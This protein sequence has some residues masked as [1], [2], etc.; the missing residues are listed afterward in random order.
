MKKLITLL[1]IVS[2]LL[3]MFSCS[4]PDVDD[5][6]NNTEPEDVSLSYLNGV[7]LKEYTI[8]YSANDLDYSKRAAE[9]IK[10]EIFARTGLT[11]PIITDDSEKRAHEIVIGN[12]S[13]DISHELSAEYDGLEFSI[14]ADE[15]SVALEGDYFIIA[16][17]AYYFIATYVPKDDYSATV[18]AEIQVLEPIVEEANNY[19]LLIGD[20]MGEYH[21][22]MFDYYENTYDYSDGEDFFYGYLLPYF[23]YSKTNSLSGV[24]DSAAGGTALSTGY[25]TYNAYVGIDKDGN[26]LQSLT[27]LFGSLGKKTGVMSTETETGATPASFS[28]HEDDRASSSDIRADQTE[29]KAQ[30]GTVIDCG[31]YNSYNKNQL[32]SLDNHIND[33]LS[34]L[35]SG[36]GFFLMYE[37]AYIDKYSHNND[38]E[39]TYKTVIRFNQAIARFMEFA[40]YNPDTMVI[41]TADHETGAL[42]PDDD[43]A[44][45]FNHDDHTGADVFVFSYG[46]GAEELD[47]VTMENIEIPMFIANCIGVEDFGDRSIYIPA[48]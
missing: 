40:F 44:L 25:K 14:M 30:Y 17:A 4:G 1:V 47:G 32:K 38:I 24:T 20:G 37:E 31:T 29:L 28:A 2:M 19:I 33:T 43:G 16:A 45:G 46:Y 12:T 6:S 26:P 27:E 9:Y 48:E 13:R 35:N 5:G 11:L 36:D 18:P 39:M 23:G 22:K 34:K 21:T 8:V 10:S 15:D 41:I 42:L 7:N 3:S